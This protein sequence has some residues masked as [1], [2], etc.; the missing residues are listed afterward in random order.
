M[1]PTAGG[2]QR[3]SLVPKA[4][5]RNSNGRLAFDLPRTALGSSARFSA[6]T[7]YRTGLRVTVEVPEQLSEWSELIQVQGALPRMELA[8]CA[9]VPLPAP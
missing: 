2:R 6:G 4:E 3:L 5:D 9:M 1:L 8:S 7:G